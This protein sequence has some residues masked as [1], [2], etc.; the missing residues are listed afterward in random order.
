MA[1]NILNAFGN[2]VQELRLAKGI[3]QEKLAHSV[4]VHRTYLGFI[5]R[6]ERNPTLENINKIASTLGVSLSDL[7]RGL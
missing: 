6:G 7:F 1:R 3:S 5:E 2:R 4:G